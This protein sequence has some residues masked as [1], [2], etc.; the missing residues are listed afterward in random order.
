MSTA[1][2]LLPLYAYMACLGTKGF[3]MQSH[4]CHILKRVRHTYIKE[5]KYTNTR[6]FSIIER[7]AS[8]GGST[9]W[10][11]SIFDSGKLK[12][13]MMI[14]TKWQGRELLLENTQLVG[15]LWWI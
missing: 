7:S 5:R 14:S 15:Y 13:W 10:C 9:R 3:I 8:C 1:V 11:K 2:S 12:L 6:S 4:N